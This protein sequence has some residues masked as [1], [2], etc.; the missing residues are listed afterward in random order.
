MPAT[1]R[2][3]RYAG[4]RYL[5]LGQLGHSA[6]MW[7]EQV[8]RPLLVLELTH[9]PLQVGLVV[10]VRMAPQFLFGLLAG[11]IADRYN[12]RRVL[13]GSQLV[14]LIMHLT[15]ALLILGGKIAVWQV[16]VTAFIS[17]GSM[18]FN[19]PARQTLIPSLVPSEIMLNA[20]ALNTAAMNAMRVLGA[21]LAGFLLIYFDYGQ[22]Y[23]VNAVLFVF[24]LWTT[25]RIGSVEKR[26]LA[27]QP[28]PTPKPREKTSIFQDL[29]EGF[30]YMGANRRVLYLVAM[31]LILFLIGQPY[32]QVFVP[33]LALNVLHI[34]RSGAGWMLALTGIGALIGSLTMASVKKFRRRGLILISFLCVFGA[35]LILLSQSR[36]F[37][38]SAVALIF[39]GAM[40]TAYNS[41]N[42]SLL[43]E[44]TPREFH[45]RVISLMSLDRGFVSLGAVLAGGL[46]EA[47]GPQLGLFALA[48]SCL[49]LTALFFFTVP[50]I[51][52]LN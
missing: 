46:A 33:L 51:R 20:I 28:V 30:R 44:E 31:A 16:F 23:L 48:L 24:V 39:A 17:G 8:V 27:D 32:Q 34:G 12:K 35:A 47:L 49:A 7:M 5:W 18:A 2:A 36:W 9:S 4:Y 41:L 15:L 6:A 21:G 37:I 38:F 42:L 22:V 19:Q 13:L 45:G 14:T 40:T 1:F 11:V 29:L 25:V 52:K 26:P 43:I 50:N 10:A 3:L